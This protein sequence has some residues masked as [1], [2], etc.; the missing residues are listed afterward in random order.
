MMLVDTG[1]LCFEIALV[2]KAGEWETAGLDIN[3]SGAL[4]SHIEST[5][6][7]AFEFKTLSFLLT[8]SSGL[9]VLVTKYT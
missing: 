6:K 9:F 7:L 2:I 3:V 8:F 4:F 1:A 5:D